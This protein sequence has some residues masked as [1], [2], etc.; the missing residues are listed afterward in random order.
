VTA[1]DRTDSHALTELANAL[2]RV[3]RLH[4][5]RSADA[6]LAQALDR[7]SAWQARRLYNTYADLAVDPRYR[8]A[9]EFFQNDLYGSGDFARRDGDLARVVPAMG[10]MLP[11][12]V[13]ATVA[14]AV[15]LNA[16]AH[17]LDRALIVHLPATENGIA[18]ADY[19][20]AYRATGEAPLRARQIALISEVGN[21][22]D[23]YVRMPMVGGALL[24]MRKPAHAAGLGALQAFLERGF[25]AFR[26]MKG[27]RN[28]LATI[29]ARERRINDAI[30]AGDDAPFP[31]P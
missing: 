6:S 2:D 27:A 4:A 28:F 7:L 18:V 20:R 21:A 8:V 17:E 19:C 29:D 16:L 30:F 14:R 15:E 12:S 13:I 9:V 5:A 10:R 25:D 31:P 11:A 26:R 22:L 3:L 23:R 1:P 24:M